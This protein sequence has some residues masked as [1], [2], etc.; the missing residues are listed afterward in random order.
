MDFFTMEEGLIT[1]D[2]REV[3][4]VVLFPVNWLCNDIV[5]LNIQNRGY[6]W[7]SMLGYCVYSS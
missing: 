7:E 6:L 3:T 1:L 2:I 5:V 4:P